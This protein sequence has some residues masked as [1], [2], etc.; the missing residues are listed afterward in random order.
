M[1]HLFLAGDAVLGPG[2]GFQALLLHLFL[3][4]GARAVFLAANAL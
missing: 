2:Y 1:F 4:V 3:A